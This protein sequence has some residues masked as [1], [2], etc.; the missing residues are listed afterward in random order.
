[1]RVSEYSEKLRD[2]RWRQKR[3]QILERD[4]YACRDCGVEDDLQVH[5]CFYSGEPWDVEDN[6][7]LTL[8]EAC[9]T[10]RQEL[11]DGLRL[12]IG[13]LCSSVKVADVERFKARFSRLVFEFEGEVIK[14]SELIDKI[15]EGNRV[16]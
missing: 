15:E 3:A 11:E 12:K 6:L 10:A 8:C 5:H 14:F 2:P 9:H 13:R 16:G 1:M 7:L 4:K